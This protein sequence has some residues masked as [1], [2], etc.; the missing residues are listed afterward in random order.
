MSF[1]HQPIR[2]FWYQNHNFLYCFKKNFLALKFILKINKSIVFIFFNGFNH[3][4]QCWIWKFVLMWI[5][6]R[7]CELIHTFVFNYYLLYPNNVHLSQSLFLKKIEI[8]GLKER[9]CL[10]CNSGGIN[11]WK[12]IFFW[13]IHISEWLLIEYFFP[14]G[15]H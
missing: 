6:W 8:F 13:N 3:Q 10:W 11:F 9:S 2:L 4:N 12:L 1:V 5:N 7:I 15:L 14:K